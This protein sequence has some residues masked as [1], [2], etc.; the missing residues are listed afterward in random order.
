MTIDQVLRSASGR[1]DPEDFRTPRLDV[2]VL[3]ASVLG[4]ERVYLHAHPER[5]LSDEEASRFE[6]LL[7]RRLK[8]EPVAYLTGI[9]EFYGLSFSVDPSVLIPRPETELIIEEAERILAK[10]YS[11]SILDLGTGSGCLAVTMKKLFPSAE[12]LA[13][14]VSPEA[15]KTAEANAEKILGPGAVRFVLSDLFSSI[16]GCFDLIVCNPPYVPDGIP[17]EPNVK[18]FEPAS[19]LFAG[20]DGLGFIRPFL[21]EVSGHLKPSGLLLMECGVE[22]VN[23]IESLLPSKLM[24]LR[25]ISDL[26]DIPRIVVVAESS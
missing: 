2:E 25:T 3:L 13:A 21:A 12:V 20:P 10:G 23:R 22:T 7:V 17:L 26:S 4:C 8:R 15:L 14:D 6:G 9:K 11:G 5:T 24:L 16:P 1:F 19:A 18:D